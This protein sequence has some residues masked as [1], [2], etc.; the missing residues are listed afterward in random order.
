[1]DGPPAPEVELDGR[2]YLLLGSNNYLDLAGHPAVM[3]GAVEAVRRHGAGSGASRVVSGATAAQADLEGRLSRLV[4]ADAAL[5]FSSGYLANV[6]TIQALVGRGD[7]VFSDAL[8]HASIIDGCRLSG[9]QVTVYPHRDVAAQDEELP[10][11]GGRRPLV[12][13]ASGVSMEVDTA[14]A[15]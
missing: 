6:S 11:S 4:G 2:R 9:A 10:A 14:P 7:A 3:A 15:R 13:S 5:L 8:N 1:L 12:V